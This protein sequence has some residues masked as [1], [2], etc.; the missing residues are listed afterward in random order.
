MT[1]LSKGL[2]AITTHI[3]TGY[4]VDTFD[5]ESMLSANFDF[6]SGWDNVWVFESI[7]TLARSAGTRKYQLQIFF[8]CFG[9]V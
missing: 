1:I 2:G 6:S 8:D 7:A 3:E 4:I 5:I 9:I